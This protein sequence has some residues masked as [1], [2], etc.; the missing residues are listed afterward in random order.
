MTT[1]QSNPLVYDGFIS[2]DDQ[3]TIIN[4]AF[5]NKEFKFIRQVVLNWLAAYPGDLY[6]NF[7]YAKAL[8][9]EGKTTQALPILE[10]I[11]AAD[12]EFAPAYELHHK[13][14]SLSGTTDVQTIAAYYAL[15]GIKL[16]NS[17]LPQWST[18]YRQSQAALD[19][20]K[21][22]DS[23]L[24][25]HQA[26]IADPSRVLPAIFHLHLVSLMQ[27]H[28]S[29][30]NLANLY[31]TR[32]IDCL[33]FSY[34]LAVAEMQT[35]NDLAAVALLHQC[36]ARDLAGQVA[37]RVFGE[38]NRY[39]TLWPDK[40]QGKFDVPVPTGIASSLGWNQLE[41][42]FVT[43]DVVDPSITAPESM[44]VN[45]AI[46]IDPAGNSELTISEA[47]S[48]QSSGT[49]IADQNSSTAIPVDF[50][51]SSA[52]AEAKDAKESKEV[53]LDIRQELDRIAARLQVPGMSRVDRRFPVY[54]VFT[55]RKGLENLYGTQ[56]A[57]IL[58]ELM[59]QVVELVRKKPGWTSLLFYADD[60]A[61]TTALG[62]KPAPFNDAWKLKLA[63][64]DLDK[65]L[66]KKGEMIGAL[67]IVGGPEVVPFH[68]LPNP[69]DDA[70]TQ[71]PS[72]NPYASVDDNYF[73][74]EWPVGRLPGGTNRDA[75]ILMQYLRKMIATHSEQVA[76]KPWW[77]R[78]NVFSPIWSSMQRAFPFAKG[79]MNNRQSFGY[80]AAV[81]S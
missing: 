78:I 58:D 32:W 5:R 38:K 48:A 57:F 44:E 75:G 25:V 28:Q 74:P 15:T 61:S 14:L 33:Y 1:N 80:T 22:E 8:I 12:P 46:Q 59:K 16:D 45:P 42:A 79:I 9:E 66:A 3:L 69:T 13:V 10:M 31:H 34:Y 55:T 50:V 30:Q 36:V 20:E 43:N 26:V 49:L 37:M 40:M 52:A 27:D 35:G 11:E 54:V 24:L 63:I 60:T 64:A 67:L 4:V 7:L 21:L 77:Q 65:A 6:F 29:L 18:L 71:V 72:D 53:L 68:L 70:D 23:E 19:N 39:R 81:W 2:R 76:P 47:T 73:I 51:Q 62:V 56:T 41:A 17:N